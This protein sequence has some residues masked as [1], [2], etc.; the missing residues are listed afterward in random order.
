M[1]KDNIRYKANYGLKRLILLKARD[2]LLDARR[3]YLIKLFKMNLSPSC[4]FSLKV[5]FDKTNPRGIYVDDE[6]YIAFGV[7]ILTHDMSREF[8]ANTKIGKRCFIGAHALIMPGVEIGDECIVGAGSV[9]T[10]SVPS[11][12]I[13]A[14]NPARLIKTGIHTKPYGKLITH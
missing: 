2:F 11:N 5:N 1:K 6:S 12:S 4:R 9:V 7:V 13:V 14:G 3:W 10:K 8:H